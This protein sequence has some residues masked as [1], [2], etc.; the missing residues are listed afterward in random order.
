LLLCANSS[1]PASSTNRK[2]STPASTSRSPIPPTPASPRC[3]AV[4]LIERGDPEQRDSAAQALSGGSLQH[5][6]LFKL[7]GLIERGDP[8]N[9]TPPPKHWAGFD[10]S[11]HVPESAPGFGKMGVPVIVVL[12]LPSASPAQ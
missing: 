1:T 11:D 3:R 2:N 4:G 12:A 10:R 6:I 9:A 8:N 7:A 5:G